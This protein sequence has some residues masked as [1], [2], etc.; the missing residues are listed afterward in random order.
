M[1]V[2]IPD[3]LTATCRYLRLVTLA[4]GA[5]P[6]PGQPIHPESGIFK[7]KRFLLLVGW[8]KSE[9]DV[10]GKQRFDDSLASVGPKDPK[11]FLRVHD[12]L[13]WVDS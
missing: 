13:E 11:D 10:K 4:L 7:G 6:K 3:P 9:R 8:R 1:W 5:A 2:D 12:L